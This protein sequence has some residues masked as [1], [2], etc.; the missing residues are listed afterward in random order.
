MNFL[1]YY[2][3]SRIK[4]VDSEDEFSSESKP[5]HIKYVFLQREA[6]SWVF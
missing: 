3:V 5:F 4:K 2:K 6:F 1:N